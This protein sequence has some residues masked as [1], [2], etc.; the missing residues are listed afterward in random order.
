MKKIA[1][2]SYIWTINILDVIL[3]KKRHQGQRQMCCCSINENS[4]KQTIAKLSMRNLKFKTY[5]QNKIGSKI[6][7]AT[8]F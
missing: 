5:K 4:L 3:D 1:L 6:S 7:T 8:D 2:M